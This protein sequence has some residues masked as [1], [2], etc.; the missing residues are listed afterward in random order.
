[1]SSTLYH[2]PFL[3]SSEVFKVPVVSGSSTVTGLNISVPVGYAGTN[4]PV[5][6]TYAA[7]GLNGVSSVQNVAVTLTGAKYTSGNNTTSTT[8]SQAS[9]TMVLVASKPTVTLANATDSVVGTGGS[10]E[11]ARVT[12]AAD[13][14]GSVALNSLPIKI[15]TAGVGETQ[16]VQQLK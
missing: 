1:M 10:I 14:K 3:D 4:V 5:T 15:A 9:N 11:I 13:A 6:A 2:F 7:V 8:T 16:E 12:I